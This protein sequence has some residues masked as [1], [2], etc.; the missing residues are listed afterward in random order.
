MKRCV[1]RFI[2]SISTAR[3]FQP[4]PPEPW[5]QVVYVKDWRSVLDKGQFL[6]VA[7]PHKARWEAACDASEEAARDTG[8]QEAYDEACR[9]AYNAAYHAVSYATE[10]PIRR[11]VACPGWDD[12]IHARRAAA[13]DAASYAAALVVADR[14]DPTPLHR[15]WAAWALG[16]VPIRED[17][18]MLV[19]ACPR[20]GGNNQGGRPAQKTSPAR[21]R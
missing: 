13:Y 9:A 4:Q 15:W 16:Y 18:D 14:V 21:G 20:P 8:R 11:G 3:F 6:S 19:V 10:R 12:I 5:M 7:C 1:R 17:G 2:K